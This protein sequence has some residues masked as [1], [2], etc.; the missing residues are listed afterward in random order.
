MMR[1]SD[2]KVRVGKLLGGS[3]ALLG[4]QPKKDFTGEH[5]LPCNLICKSF[6]CSGHSRLAVDQQRACM[7]K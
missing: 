5:E 2:L 4:R 3:I 1:P 6:V 7:N